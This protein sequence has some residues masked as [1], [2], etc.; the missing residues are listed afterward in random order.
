LWTAA[1]PT[2]GF[3]TAGPLRGERSADV[4]VIGGGAAGLAVALRLQERG[5]EV[6]V[7][8][9]HRIGG[10]VTGGSTAKVTALHG[11]LL[12]E[13]RR[14]HGAAVARTYAQANLAGLADIRATVERYGIDCGL[15]TAPAVDYATTDAGARRVETEL[16]ACRDAGLPVERWS[17]ADDLLAELPFAPAVTAA[18]ALPD[19]AHVHPLRWCEGMASAIGRDRV[20]E[21]TAVL[22]VDDEPGGV[23]ATT[24]HGDV[25][26]GHAVI[27][28][29]GPIVDPRYLTVRCRPHRSYA[30]AAQVADPAAVPAGMY[31]SVDPDAPVRSLRPAVV[32]GKPYLVVAGEGHPVGDDHAHAA[33]DALEGWTREHFA[34][35]A[36]DHRWAAHDQVPSDALPFV[37]RLVPGGRRWVA[38]GFQKWGLTT[39]AVAAAVIADGILG[40]EADADAAS[41]ARI[42]DPTRLRSTL[43]GRLVADVGR[44]AQR[45]VGDHVTIRRPSRDRDALVT[46]LAPGDGVVLPE[47]RGGM[48]VHRDAD[49]RLHAVSAVCTHEGC[50]VRFNS[51]QISW[52]CPCHGSR[53]SVDGE[54]LSGPAVDDLPALD[55]PG[56][57]LDEPDEAGQ[58]DQAATD[59]GSG[60]SNTR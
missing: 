56:R 4:V 22:A 45:Y 7:L 25:H 36:V 53:F 46:A 31:L 32:A 6:I 24:A 13:I 2:P 37:G 27:A 1:P 59:S 15:T 42:L 26:A 48:A 39:S 50:L 28:T 40:A 60:S 55:P 12:S 8:E 20:H 30:L 44:V 10:G 9:R 35:T 18:L 33:L 47:G 3:A 54:V 19:Q 16:A 51:A 21:A 38:T 29:H 34:V 52:D 43:T 58:A 23:T 11:T 49:G 41:V 14:L 57:A 5:A 17:P